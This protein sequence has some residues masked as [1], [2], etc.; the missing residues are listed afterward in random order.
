MTIRQLNPHELYD[1][2]ASGMSQGVVDQRSGLVFISGQVAWDVNGRVSGNGVGEQTTLAL[3]NLSVVLASAGCTA[4]DVLSVRVYVRGELA[5]HLPA[6]VPAL[7][8]FFGATRPALTGIGVA[9]LATPDTL[10][11]IEVVARLPAKAA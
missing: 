7:V 5:D 1:S 3:E 9:S 10:I 11:E 2:A 8:S 6:C 4:A